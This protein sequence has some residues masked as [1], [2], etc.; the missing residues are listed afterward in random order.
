MSPEELCDVV[1]D[2]LTGA[3]EKISRSGSRAG[4]DAESEADESVEASRREHYECWYRKVEVV[5]KSV[6]ELKS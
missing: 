2:N 3:M 5:L 1:S 6:E 4:S